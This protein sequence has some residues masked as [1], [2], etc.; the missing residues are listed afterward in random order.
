MLLLD[1]QVLA[2]GGGGHFWAQPDG[3]G[4]RPIVLER[5]ACMKGRPTLDCILRFSTAEV[6]F[7]IRLPSMGRLWD[8]PQ[9]R[10]DT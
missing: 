9:I 2:T 6:A 4:V 8:T 3:I 5:V 7:S 1:A 10:P